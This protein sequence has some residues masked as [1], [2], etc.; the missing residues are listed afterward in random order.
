MVLRT[1][2]IFCGIHFNVTVISD[3]AA[4]VKYPNELMLHLVSHYSL[5]SIYGSN[6]SW[7][8]QPILHALNELISC[9]VNGRLDISSNM[10]LIKTDRMFAVCLA[11][12]Y[13]DAQN[14]YITD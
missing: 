4:T 11:L 3:F 5:H 6:F 2:F 8:F 10:Q 7:S 13:L 12:D 1:A 9:H 14:A